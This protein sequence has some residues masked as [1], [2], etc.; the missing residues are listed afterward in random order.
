MASAWPMVVESPGR[1]QAARSAIPAQTSRLAHSVHPV[2]LVGVPAG[3]ALGP[4]IVALAA[5]ILV[6][7]GALTVLLPIAC[8][9]AGRLLARRCGGPAWTGRH[10]PP[11][12][13][14]GTSRCDDGGERD[15]YGCHHQCLNP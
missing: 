6:L 14:V 1:R 9:G 3:L 10:V 5:L 15:R 13:L 8:R 11:C 12:M 2:C 4:T 7:V